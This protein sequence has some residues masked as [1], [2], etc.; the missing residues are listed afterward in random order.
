MLNICQTGSCFRAT[1]AAGADKELRPD[2]GLRGISS[3]SVCSNIYELG[4]RLTGSW[5]LS[6]QTASK[7][8]RT[9]GRLRLPDEAKFTHNESERAGHKTN[10]RAGNYAPD[11]A[12]AA[13]PT[14]LI[15]LPFST[16]PCMKLFHP[17]ANSWTNSVQS[18]QPRQLSAA[19]AYSSG[20]ASLFTVHKL[21][22]SAT[23]AV[24]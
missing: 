21:C 23:L 22:N 4:R 1:A 19:H 7:Q 8:N 20:C 6:A 11:P 17:N 15:S 9:L 3:S 18:G 10:L 13:W 16:A 14:W 24:L 12:A 2:C 5:R